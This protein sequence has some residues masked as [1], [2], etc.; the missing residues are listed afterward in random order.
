VWENVINNCIVGFIIFGVKVPV[1]VYQWING[2]NLADYKLLFNF[3]QFLI[4]FVFWVVSKRYK[5]F[6]VGLGPTFFVIT[7]TCLILLQN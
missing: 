4:V 3:A 2:N 7:G 6:I 1:N 5:W